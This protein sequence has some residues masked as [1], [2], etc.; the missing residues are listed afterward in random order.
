MEDCAEGGLL[1]RDDS[2]PGAPNEGLGLLNRDSCAID[3]RGLV[4]VLTALF[5]L[6]KISLSVSSA[7]IFTGGGALSL[8]LLA[9]GD[10]PLLT[11]FF[12]SSFSDFKIFRESQTCFFFFNE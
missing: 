3:C 6:A 11:L 7:F 4:M 8:L 1:N 10:K 2:P 5:G 9:I 12:P